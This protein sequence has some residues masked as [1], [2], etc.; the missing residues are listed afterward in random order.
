VISRRQFVT[1][2]SLACLGSRCA[3][4]RAFPDVSTSGSPRSAALPVK[5]V[6]VAA[7]A[8]I[9]F[10]HENAASAEKYLIETMGAGCEWM[11]YDQNG[12]LGASL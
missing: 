9:H 3:A 8:K 5:F 6:D 1:T 10:Q 4:V 7:A 12:W 11:D 2:A